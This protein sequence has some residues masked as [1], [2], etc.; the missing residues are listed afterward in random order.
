[1]NRKWVL[2][3]VA[4]LVVASQCIAQDTAA[5][6]ENT[7]PSSYQQEETAESTASPEESFEEMDDTG[8]LKQVVDP[9]ES[10][11][12]PV[13]DGDVVHI[14]YAGMHKGNMIDYAGPDKSGNNN[15]RIVELG[16]N[17]M[18]KGVERAIIGHCPKTRLRIVIPPELAFDD[19]D[20]MI[21]SKPVPVG[22]HVNYDVLVV[23]YETPN[24]VREV[25]GVFGYIFE[26]IWPILAVSSIVGAF[27]SWNRR[28]RQQQKPKPLLKQK[29][30]MSG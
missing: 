18:L 16:K 21:K 24:I 7:M 17:Q 26:Q 6:D 12:D 19:P 22:A 14:M 27:I 20:L 1:M 8:L 29:L 5:N 3:L 28:S 10:C 23:E 30:G 25:Q 2:I 15:G 11:D 9:G 13:R 4:C